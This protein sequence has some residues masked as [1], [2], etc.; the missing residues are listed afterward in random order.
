[1]SD[2]TFDSIT[3][4]VQNDCIIRTPP[5]P[6]ICEHTVTVS[7]DVMISLSISTPCQ[8]GRTHHQPRAQDGVTFGCAAPSWHGH[9]IL[10]HKHAHHAGC[11]RLR[12]FAYLSIFHCICEVIGYALLCACGYASLLKTILCP[13]QDIQE[14]H[15][16]LVTGVPVLHL[17]HSSSE[18]SL[19]YVSAIFTFVVFK[20]VFAVLRKL[21]TSRP[22]SSLA[23]LL[24][25][26][27][28]RV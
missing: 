16:L 5:S 14:A 11:H 26:R 27:S 18:L 22:R 10:D 1:M 20:Y 28:F 25:I 12:S 2:D 15:H 23:Y 17:E 8:L 7:H 24:V 21:S 6:V 3:L 9:H 13:L 19:R 4:L